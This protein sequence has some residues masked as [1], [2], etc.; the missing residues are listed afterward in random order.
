M[1]PWFIMSIQYALH[2]F[3]LFIYTKYKASNCKYKLGI[4]SSKQFCSFVS[5]DAT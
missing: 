1:F 4:V 3:Y 5:L 2:R